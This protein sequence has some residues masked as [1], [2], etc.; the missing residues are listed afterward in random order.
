M[1][2][3]DRPDSRSKLLHAAKQAGVSKVSSAAWDDKA[4]DILQAEGASVE[5][6]FDG[7]NEERERYYREHFER[8]RLAAE[9]YRLYAGEASEFTAASAGA[10]AEALR[11]P[12][13]PAPRRH[14]LQRSHHARR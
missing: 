6:L 11:H 4:A 1:L 5:E 8:T 7:L 3:E 2:S 10:V 13:V 12:Q 9:G 14:R